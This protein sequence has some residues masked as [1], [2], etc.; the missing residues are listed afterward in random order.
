VRSDVAGSRQMLPRWM[1]LLLFS[2]VLAAAPAVAADEPHAP[3]ASSAGTFEE[4]DGARALEGHIMAPCCWTQTI[5][6]HGSEIS[7]E[8]RREIRTRLKAGETADAITQD[9]V[10]RYGEKILAVPPGNPLADMATIVAIG[11]LGAGVGA[12]FMLR[13]WRRRG[14]ESEA[15]KKKQKGP[16]SRDALDDQIDAELEKL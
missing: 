7:N 16:T 5:D 2:A 14:N 13:R 10:A 8:L 9:F 12:V 1:S 6:I 3:P 4:V 15:K 11:F